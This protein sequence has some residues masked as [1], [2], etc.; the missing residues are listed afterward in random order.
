MSESRGRFDNGTG[1]KPIRRGQS[2]HPLS[3]ILYASLPK[4]LR[5]T[6]SSSSQ[7]DVPHLLP[8]VTNVI[9]GSLV[10]KEKVTFFILLSTAA[11]IGG[12]LLLVLFGDHSAQSYTVNQLLDLY[13][14]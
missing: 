1:G 11:I 8:A 13:A 2:E 9:F 6:S 10:L 4:K 3:H 12:C 5:D 14:E 7:A